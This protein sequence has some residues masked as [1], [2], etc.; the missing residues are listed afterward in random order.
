MNAIFGVNNMINVVFDM[1]KHNQ[2]SII[3]PKFIL[4]IMLYKQ[5]LIR[6]I[7]LI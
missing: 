4:Y 1:T 5:N 3:V 7:R 2:K 6:W